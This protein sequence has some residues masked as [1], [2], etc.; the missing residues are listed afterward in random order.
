MSSSTK[1]KA[2]K[3][4]QALVSTTASSGA[5]STES[6][7]QEP[8]V[9]K[10]RKKKIVM[11][12]KRAAS[13]A[14]EGS[15]SKKQKT[16][17][18]VS[19]PSLV[20]ASDSRIRLLKVPEN[21]EANKNCASSSGASS[22]PGSGSSAVYPTTFGPNL[23]SLF[24]NAAPF[25]HVIVDGFL[26]VEF[27]KELRLEMINSLEVKPKE[28]D[29]FKFHQTQD[30]ASLLAGSSGGHVLASATPEGKIQK[31]YP[32]LQKL[33]SLL[34]SEAFRGKLEDYL[35]LDAKLIDR[36][37]MSAQAYT[38]GCHLMC[39]DDV[40]STRKLT[41][42]LYLDEP[43]G[44]ESS[45]TPHGHPSTSLSPSPSSL[46]SSSSWS[47][48]WGGG[49]EFYTENDP[50]PVGELLPDF[51]TLLL[52]GVEPGKSY[53]A[54]RE[55]TH[56]DKTRLS[57]QGWYHVE[58]IDDT[59]SSEKRAEKATLQQLVGGGGNATKNAVADAQKNNEKD[60]DEE[61]EKMAVLPEGAIDLEEEA[62]SDVLEE[63]E[64]EGNSISIGGG[65][66]KNLEEEPSQE[67]D[68]SSESSEDSVNEESDMP[69][70]FSSCPVLTKWIKK[71]YLSQKGLFQLRQHFS[72]NSEVLLAD[73]LHTDR[74]IAFLKALREMDRK[75]GIKKDT[76][77]SS[78]QVDAESQAVSYQ[79]GVKSD[80][81]MLGP[82][83]LQRYLV[84]DTA[85]RAKTAKAEKNKKTIKEQVE[86][87]DPHS[88]LGQSLKQ[89][90][91]TLMQTAEFQAFLRA[92]V[93]LDFLDTRTKPS[94]MD[95]NSDDLR[96]GDE[97]TDA[98]KILRQSQPQ[99]RRFRPGLDYTI[100]TVQNCVR[101]CNLVDVCYTLVDGAKELVQTSAGAKGEAD[102]V[103]DEGASNSK[104]TS[105]K[106]KNKNLK[107]E[108][109]Q[110]SSTAGAAS[111]AQLPETVLLESDHDKQYLWDSEEVGGF[112]S[113]V[114]ADDDETDEKAEVY[115][116]DD[117]QEG[118]D[119]EAGEQ[120]GEQG[121]DEQN[122]VDKSGGKNPASSSAGPLLNIPA[123]HNS[124]SIVLRD[125][126]TLSF[127]KFLASAA[128]SSRVDVKMSL[129]VETTK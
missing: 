16:D 76:S 67:E 92:I 119:E 104:K 57:L 20:L 44:D 33:A 120:Q 90:V 100:A 101:R 126:K 51:N 121:G 3:K 112:E 54:V 32:S 97:E 13:A 65:I 88:F 66:K 17:K 2:M 68:L 42:V 111:E 84:F 1:A 58:S 127:L 46:S 60:A 29:L 72:D 86:T 53:H 75:D 52:F 10:A 107:I 82:A 114:E 124:L 36:V 106:K 64:E 103:E 125:A 123:F 50:A 56:A 61:D 105:K 5:D 117:D 41:F 27:C 102:E 6:S 14:G 113:Y 81:K 7:P 78:A 63:E 38:Q 37:D 9:A 74:A 40:I 80:W 25:R 87:S 83:F 19:L 55:V 115:R 12:K 11:K 116:D 108:K 4:R 30:L 79:A 94:S 59:Y 8:V 23:G 49:M 26:D 118:E 129:P 45:S 48:A 18:Q 39:H 70:H 22:S 21:E 73:F 28:T 89:L 95:S 98:A 35:G 34:Y 77:S 71:E 69:S 43:G 24:N 96:D 31:A 128:P 110:Q 15:S 47:P 85:D 109:N 93:G 62:D 91:E 99:I 122:Q